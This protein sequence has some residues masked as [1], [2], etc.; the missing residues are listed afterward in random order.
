MSSPPRTAKERLL[1]ELWATVLAT[2]LHKIGVDSDFFYLGGDSV[3]AMKL[4]SL[5]RQR[6]L[7]L[8]VADIFTWSTL[9]EQA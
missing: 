1:Q 6:G 4:T 2:P 7:T 9:A 8:A 5:L 3:Q